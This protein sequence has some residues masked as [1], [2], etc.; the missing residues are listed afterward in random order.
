LLARRKAMS[1]GYREME[2]ILRKELPLPHHPAAI[3]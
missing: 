1:A 3:T 2:K